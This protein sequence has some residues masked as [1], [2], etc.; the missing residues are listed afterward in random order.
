MILALEAE[1]KFSASFVAHLLSRNSRI[2]E[3]LVDQ[4]FSSRE[5]RLA[6][7][8]LLLADFGKKGAKP[9][10]VT[11]SQEVLAGMIGTTRSRVSFFEHVSKKRLHQLQRKFVGERRAAGQAAN[12]GR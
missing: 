6:H 1:P 3:D 4:L 7:P 11:L 5:R 10:A 9:V 12:L 2:E 8:L